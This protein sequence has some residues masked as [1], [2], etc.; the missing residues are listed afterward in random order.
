MQPQPCKMDRIYTTVISI[1]LFWNLKQEYMRIYVA[2]FFAQIAT[3]PWLD[4]LWVLGV[5]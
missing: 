5:P 2:P 4:N 1:V 3:N